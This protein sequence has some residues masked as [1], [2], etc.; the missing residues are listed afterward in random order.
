[1][2]VMKVDSFVL[3]ASAEEGVDELRVV[4]DENLLAI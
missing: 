1:M 2:R 4:D 3:Q